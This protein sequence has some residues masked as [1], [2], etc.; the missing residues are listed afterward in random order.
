MRNISKTQRALA[1]AALAMT[2]SAGSGKAAGVPQPR[3]KVLVVLSSESKITL[4]NDVV[5]PTGFFLPELMVPVKKLIEAGYQPVFADPK[6]TP[7]VMDRVS[8]GAFWFG[9]VPG[10][11]AQAKA[12]AQSD[13]REIRELC[14]Q[15]GI[16]G[17]DLTGARNLESLPEIVAGGLEQYV[18][19]LVPGG[20][21]PMEDLLKDLDLGTILRHFHDARKPTALICHGPIA[22]L[23]AMTD[24]G[25]FVAALEKG[26]S[27]AAAKH[28][29]NWIYKG[30]SMAIFTTAEEKQEEPGGQD[31]ALGGF[32]KFYPDYAL[33]RA[34]GK[35]QPAAKWTPNVVV[36]R[37]LITGQNP[38]SDKALA[39]ALVKALAKK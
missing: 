6:G 28:A 4:K 31:N 30:Y 13:Y 35:V 10:A 39:D 17:D 5:H 21:A 19:V 24:P 20:H 16:C 34:G 12:Q 7:A 2:L 33:S 22:L 15:L 25:S 3:G 18:G 36:D 27:T 14:R 8:D 11:S 9:D 32:V 1:A 37:E 29:K 38:M 26:D 23:S